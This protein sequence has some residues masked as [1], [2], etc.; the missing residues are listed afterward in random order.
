MQPASSGSPL[1]N[2]DHRVI[3]QLYG[4]S[5]CESFQCENPSLQVV[6][7]G[8]FSVSWTGNGATDP[9]RRLKDWLDPF[10]KNPTTLDG[11]GSAPV[12]TLVGTIQQ[13]SCGGKPTLNVP[14]N[15][16][17]INYVNPG[18]CEVTVKMTSNSDNLTCSVNYPQYTYS[19]YKSGSVW[20]L[21][22]SIQPNT[23]TPRVFYID[24]GSGSTL[25]LPFFL[26]SS[27]NLT[28]DSN[29]TNLTFPEEGAY[30]ITLYDISGNQVK[31]SSFKSAQTAQID[32]SNLSGGVYILIITDGMGNKVG[33][34]KIVISR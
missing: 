19:F 8:K 13:S 33:E 5:W 24:N 3:G 34:E 26:F 11:M 22:F 28:Y 32:I 15:V 25:Q 27:Y 20:Y 16:G 10:G 14:V 12:F 18:G 29:L 30:T 1:I 21:V 2:N 17:G 23:S 31:S 7:Y 6:N 9:R 4:P